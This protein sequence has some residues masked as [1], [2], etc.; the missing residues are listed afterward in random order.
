ME[1]I[2][3]K[4]PMRYVKYLHE[5]IKRDSGSVNRFVICAVCEKINALEAHN[6]L[7]QRQK[8]ADQQKFLKSLERIPD[9]QP[10]IDED[11]IND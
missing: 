8:R 5:I 7:S 9:D 10:I 3:V 11:K 2:I 1:I 4:L 6:Y